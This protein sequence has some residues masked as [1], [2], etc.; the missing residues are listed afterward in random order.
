MPTGPD[1]AAR[2]VRPELPLVRRPTRIRFERLEDRSLPSFVTAVSFPVGTS[3]GEGSKPDG[4]AVADFNR[5]GKPDIA[6]ANTGHDSISI[7]LGTGTGK[8]APAKNIKLGRRPAELTAADVNGDGKPDLITAN[9]N[10]NS[11]SVLLGNGLG[12][13]VS[14]GV[15]GG[16]NKP[17]APAAAD[18]NGDG[19][20]DLAVPNNGSSTVTILLG[21][22]KGKFLAGPV[23]TTGNSPTAIAVGDFNGD[24][25]PD[26]ATTSGGFG[27]LDVT[28]NTGN[29]TFAAKANWATGFCANSLAVA[30]FNH[31]DI[32]DIAIGCAFPAGEVNILLG[33]GDGTFPTFTTYNP[34]N[35]SPRTIAVGDVNGDGN[36]DVVTAN[37]G[38]VNNSVTVLTG[39]GDG[40]LNTGDVFAAS[41]QPLGIA[42]GDFNRDGL[43]DVAATNTGLPAPKP[44]GGPVGVVTVLLS[45]G[46]GSVNGSPG[47]AV[48]GAGGVATG[49]L[50]GDGLTDLAVVTNGSHR[51][52]YVFPGLGNGLFGDRIASPVIDGPSLLAVGH[53]NAD[54]LL[55]VAIIA[56]QQVSVLLGTGGGQFAAPTAYATVGTPKFL[57]VADVNGD[58]QADLVLTTTSG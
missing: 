42:V 26:F 55:D 11:V 10:D 3:A 6:T 22:G 46:D 33:V 4:I 16:L 19:L 1:L 15:V 9:P 31:D 18:F 48:Q 14:A 37:D 41:I 30:D 36:M 38:F 58:Q 2:P 45:N 43:A 27:H 47:L 20:V 5:D 7:L 52:F 17:V 23:L 39:N 35:Q 40:T 25:K 44:W 51:G 21:Q 13:F 32:P 56:N 28:L 50:T 8:F 53:F 34:G 57:A 49:D 54:P 24:G 29:G 12:G